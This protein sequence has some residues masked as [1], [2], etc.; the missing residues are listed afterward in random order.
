MIRDRDQRCSD[1]FFLFSA[2]VI[3]SIYIYIYLIN[4]SLEDLLKRA[5]G[6]Q[7]EVKRELSHIQTLSVTNAHRETM[8]SGLSRPAYKFVVDNSTRGPCLRLNCTHLVRRGT[9]LNYNFAVA[10]DD[11]IAPRLPARLLNRH[12]E[13]RATKFIQRGRQEARLAVLNAKQST[14]SRAPEIVRPSVRDS[15]GSEDYHARRR[16]NN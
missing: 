7:R 15:T 5:Q 8:K 2:C 6:K 3:L 14:S 12:F 4:I 9:F 10:K 13:T 1:I 16:G 11:A